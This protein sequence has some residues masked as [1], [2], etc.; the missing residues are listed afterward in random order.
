[1]AGTDGALWFTEFLGNKVGRLTTTGTFTEY[2]V[3]T[4]NAKP[5]GITT[6]PDGNIWFTEV[7]GHKL[8]RLT[9]A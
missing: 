4:A 6:G 3:P 8:G 5:L 2:P 7:T 9:A 1:M